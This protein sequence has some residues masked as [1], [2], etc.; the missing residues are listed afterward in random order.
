MDVGDVVLCKHK[1]V[2]TAG[3]WIGLT[4]SNGAFTWKDGTSLDYTNWATGQP[5]NAPG[6]TC[7]M[8]QYES[9]NCS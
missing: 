9:V 5:D 1:S 4:S 2:T 8:S 3:V 7:V 6:A